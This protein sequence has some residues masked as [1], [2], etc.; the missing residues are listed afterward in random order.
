[1]QF[2]GGHHRET[3]LQVKTHL[4]TKTTDGSG[5]GAVGFLE[6]PLSIIC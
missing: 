4:V 2:L 1:M 5:A 6:T 3:F